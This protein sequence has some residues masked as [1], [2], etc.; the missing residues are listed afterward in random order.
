MNFLVSCFCTFTPPPNTHVGTIFFYNHGYWNDWL[1][2]T[3][4]YF[5]YIYIF[6]NDL[7]SDLA[8]HITH[9]VNNTRNTQC[10][11]DK[12]IFG[13]KKKKEK[14]KNE[15]IHTSVVGSMWRHHSAG[16]GSHS[17]GQLPN[18]RPVWMDCA[19]GER[20]QRRA[21]VGHGKQ[22]VSETDEKVHK[23][24]FITVVSHGN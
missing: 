3:I 18:K 19:S 1:E 10:S 4:S 5:L 20:Q 16:A 12:Q 13:V 6:G 15:Y 22:L 11:C 24:P 23:E 7:P 9:T 8:C 14:G 21:E 2:S 17:L